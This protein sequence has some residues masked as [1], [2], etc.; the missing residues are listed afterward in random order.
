MLPDQKRT[1][2][3]A[4]GREPDNVSELDVTEML[5]VNMDTHFDASVGQ[6]DGKETIALSKMSERRWANEVSRHTFL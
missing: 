3:T 2:G 5:E 1:N 4:D 6:A